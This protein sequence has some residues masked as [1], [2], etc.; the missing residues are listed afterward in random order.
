MFY[1]KALKGYLISNEIY[2][3]G[4]NRSQILFW[5]GNKTH[6]IRRMGLPGV[7]NI[8][9]ITAIGFGA[10]RQILLSSD[11]GKRLKGKMASYLYLKY[12]DLSE[13]DKKVTDKKN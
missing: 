10:D 2:G 8:E 3:E 13:Q 11:D 6:T 12:I 4:K 7:R 9:G 1:D 5:D